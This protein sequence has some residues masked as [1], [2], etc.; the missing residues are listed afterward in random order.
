MIEEK[1]KKIES[2]K[3]SKPF[4]TRTKNDLVKIELHV[5]RATFGNYEKLRQ[6]MEH[7]SIETTIFRL[8][9]K[10]I[11]RKLGRFFVPVPKQLRSLLDAEARKKGTDFEDNIAEILSNHLKEVEA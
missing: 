4:Y 7:D 1:P 5:P 10:E 8:M 9:E 3:T 2:F 6:H 11:R